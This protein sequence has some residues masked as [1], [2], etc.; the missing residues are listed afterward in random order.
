[1][2][3]YAKKNWAASIFSVFC[4]K[5][6]NQL[7][8]RF[9]WFKQTDIRLATKGKNRIRGGEWANPLLSNLNKNVAC[10]L[11]TV[12]WWASL[13]AS[14]LESSLHVLLVCSHIQPQRFCQKIRY[15]FNATVPRLIFEWWKWHRNLGIS[16]NY[17]TLF[18]PAFNPVQIWHMW[19]CID[20]WYVVECWLNLQMF[21]A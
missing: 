15:N 10:Q 6:I 7:L 14:S 12:I 5:D 19:L 4:R 16:W 20:S 18:A 11:V 3:N 21:L 1:M 13:V 17:S 2:T 9:C 8:G